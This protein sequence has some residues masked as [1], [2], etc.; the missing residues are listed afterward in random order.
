MDG[1][2]RAFCR[3]VAILNMPVSFRIELKRPGPPPRS[4]FVRIGLPLVGA[5]RGERANIG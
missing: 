2:E 1:H 3:V 4:N 5:I